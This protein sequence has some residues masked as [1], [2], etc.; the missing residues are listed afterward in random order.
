M[1]WIVTTKKF[2]YS[3]SF[4]DADASR[5]GRPRLYQVITNLSRVSGV[6]VCRAIRALWAS[7]ESSG[8]GRDADA[9]ASHSA[10]ILPKL[11]EHVV[12]TVQRL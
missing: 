3:L 8:S 9:D 11:L 12:R 6:E 7:R 2:L 4:F 5:G 1:A 10:C